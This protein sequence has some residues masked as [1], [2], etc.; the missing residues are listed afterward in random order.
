MPTAARATSAIWPLFLSNND[1]SA[2]IDADGLLTAGRRGEAFVM[3][4][5][6]THTVGSQ[7]LVLPA[8]SQF[9]PTDEAPANYIDELVGAK[10]RTMRINPSD[11]CSDE[12]FLRRVTLDVAGLLPT[13][14]EYDAFIADANSAEAGRQDRRAAGA[15]RVRRDLG[16]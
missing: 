1:S 12:E 4:R 2:A 9:T 10:L 3:A 11:V 15:Q 6:D 5:F 13:R 16:A 8:G 14:D 7:V